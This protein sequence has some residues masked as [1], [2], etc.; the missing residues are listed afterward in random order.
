MEGTP[1]NQATQEHVVEDPLAPLRLPALAQISDFWKRY[2]RLA[3]IH[4]KKMTSNLNTNLDVLLI[5]AALFSGINTTFISITMPD[6]SP[7]PADETSTLIRLL[8][9]RA[10]NNTLT[11]ADLAPPFSPNSTSIVVNCLLYASLSCSLLAAVGAMMAKEWLQSFDRTGQTGPL[12][13][14]GRFRQL[15]FNGVE[16]W[17]LE[18]VIKFLPNLLLLSVVLFFAG[19]GLF[20]LPINTAVAGIVIAFSGLGV[21]LS[22]IAIVSGAV[23]PLCPYQSAASS[24]L[25]RIY[26]APLNSWRTILRAIVYPIARAMLAGVSRFLDITYPLWMRLRQLVRLPF[27]GHAPS[28]TPFP[29]GR[30]AGALSFPPSSE[31]GEDTSDNSRE[32]TSDPRSPFALTRFRQL[33]RR[34]PHAGVKL[35]ENVF[36]FLTH[37]DNDLAMPEGDTAHSSW[38]GGDNEKDTGQTVCAHA[39]RWLLDTTSNRADQIAAAQFIRSLDRN[40]CTIVFKDSGAWRRMLSL[41]REAF[42]VWRSQPNESNQE[43]AEL[44]GWAICHVPVRLSEDIVQGHH[45]TDPPPHESR[46]F[47]E[48]FLQALEL[49]RNK[50]SIHE[51]EDEEYILH[52]AFLSSLIRRRLVINQY[53]WAKLSRLIVTGETH[54]IADT[55][56]GLWAG[57]VQTMGHKFG[58]FESSYTLA[59]L[60]DLGENK[61]LLL[62]N[63]STALFWSNESLDSVRGDLRSEP[64]AVRGYTMCLRRIRA[65]AQQSSPKILDEASRGVADVLR[66]FIGTLTTSSAETPSAEL[67]TLSIEVVLGL[68]I[69]LDNSGSNDLSS[70]Q[71]L[72]FQEHLDERLIDAVADMML[73]NPQVPTNWLWMDRP[74]KPSLIRTLLWLWR[75]TAD[76]PTN[77][78][79][80]ERIFLSSCRLWAPL[81]KEVDFSKTGNFKH[82]DKP[83]TSDDLNKIIEFIEFLRKDRKDS[84]FI[85]RNADVGINRLYVH[86]SQRV[87]WEYD[88][89]GTWKQPMLCARSFHL[90]NG[91][92]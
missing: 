50:F 41:T 31:G 71:N 83:L 88:L 54:R 91:L 30:R 14:Q 82:W 29:G 66:G 8:V 49:A 39:A 16:Q 47:G 52:V 73:D 17:R 63:L 42:D 40:A 6:L 23:S 37:Q 25:R 77:G 65:L 70:S 34:A 36:P 62:Q 53:Q 74:I 81:E 60:L 19:I 24:A 11:P 2:D 28:T 32:E 5:F 92:L 1:A 22:G 44:F 3:D 20:L 76:I 68:R 69:F 85:S 55:L 33:L 80:G 46:S 90:E 72:H 13:E 38:S 56:L 27:Q 57:F 59:E 10:D 7:N 86:F 67:V 15:K 45:A 61:E 12:E 4:D 78:R 79:E 84:A 51:P 26:G 43:V 21:I 75:N 64:D 89:F 18:A 48:T 58:E 9:L 35:L 87:E